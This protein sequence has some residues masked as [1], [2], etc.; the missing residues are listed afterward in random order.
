MDKNDN[1]QRVNSYPS[2]PKPPLPKHIEKVTVNS[3]NVTT[4]QNTNLSQSDNNCLQSEGNPN[5]P[6][7]QVG[8]ESFIIEDETIN[9]IP[10]QSRPLESISESEIYHDNVGYVADH[11]ATIPTIRIQSERI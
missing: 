1:P 11:R 6:T 8:G 9:N 3:N 5:T 4:F 7:F 2:S 10:L